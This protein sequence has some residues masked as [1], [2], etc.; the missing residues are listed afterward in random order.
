M[1]YAAEDLGYLTG[2]LLLAAEAEWTAGLQ[3]HGWSYAQAVRFLGDVRRHLAG[4]SPLYR[5]EE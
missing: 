5:L 2:S 1:K 4:R 3:A